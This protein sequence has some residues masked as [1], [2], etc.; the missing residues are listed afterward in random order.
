MAVQ[1]DGSVVLKSFLSFFFYS[2]KK[3]PLI[4]SDGTSS[5]SQIFLKSS[6]VAVKKDLYASIGRPSSPGTSC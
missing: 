1:S 5:V 6:S 3:T 2:M 4:I